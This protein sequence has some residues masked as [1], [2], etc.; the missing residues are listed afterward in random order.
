V[1]TYAEVDHLHEEVFFVAD[2]AITAEQEFAGF[3]AEGGIA[4]AHLAF[5]GGGCVEFYQLF[6]VG[7]ALH[8]C[9]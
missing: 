1:G 2:A 3:A 8:M 7:W 9:F 5:L 4:I 6:F